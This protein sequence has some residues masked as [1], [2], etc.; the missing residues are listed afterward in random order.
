MGD[1]TC[2]CEAAPRCRSHDGRHDSFACWP[3]YEPPAADGRSADTN[4]CWPTRDVDGRALLPTAL[5]SV[6]RDSEG[7]L[8]GKSVR[9]FDEPLLAYSVEKLPFGAELIFQFYGNA[10]EKP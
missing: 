7:P 3:A 4:C 8:S 10:A 5:P 2:R 9:P 6:S 1:C